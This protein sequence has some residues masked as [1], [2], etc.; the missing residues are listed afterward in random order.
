M[1]KNIRI[2][3]TALLFV[4]SMTVMAQKSTTQN[5]EEK[6]GK[7]KI[8]VESTENGKTQVFEHS[9]SIAGMNP[10]EK[11]NLV[12]HV[13]DSLSSSLGKG[14]RIKIAKGNEAFAH[15]FKTPR[16]GQKHIEIYRD[17]KRIDNNLGGNNFKE[18]RYDF[19]SNKLLGS[20]KPAM[21]EFKFKFDKDFKD[22]EFFEDSKTVKALKVYPNKPFDNKLNLKFYSPE[23]GDVNVT[24]TDVNGKEVGSQKFK[25]FQGDFMG[26]VELKKNTKG[27]VFVT[28]TQG[29][30]GTAKRVVIE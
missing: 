6:D 17:G 27:T 14:I 24:V 13:L 9:Y 7:I 4:F 8:H 3:G 12:N 16:N 21:K 23:K 22:F 1:Q 29:E 26:Q 5:I 18:F 30:D 10:E 15:S 25:D 28:I 19:D 2:F 11:E 20:I